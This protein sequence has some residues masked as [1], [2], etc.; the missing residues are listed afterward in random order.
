MAISLAIDGAQVALKKGR[1]SPC[2]DTSHA[3][4]GY[5][6]KIFYDEAQFFCSLFA[7]FLCKDVPKCADSGGFARF[8]VGFI[9][10][11]KA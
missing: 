6:D 2:S 3:K 10:N 11:K 7:V 1:I 4:T 9:K 5:I 8:V